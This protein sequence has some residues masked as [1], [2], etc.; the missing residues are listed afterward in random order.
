MPSNSKEIEE[1]LRNPKKAIELATN[2]SRKHVL[3]IPATIGAISSHF[4]HSAMEVILLC[5][6]GAERNLDLAE[7]LL[8]SIAS[9]APELR[10]PDDPLRRSADR[11]T[12]ART[13]ENT[14]VRYSDVICKA[15]SLCSAKSSCF[16]KE[17]VR[18]ASSL[19]STLLQAQI[20]TMGTCLQIL[21]SNKVISPEIFNNDN[22]IRV[23][24]RFWLAIV[25]ESRPG[26]VN[27]IV[28]EALYSC[29][30]VSHF[31]RYNSDFFDF[32]IEENGGDIHDTVAL[33]ISEL[34]ATTKESLKHSEDD[35]SFKRGH[36]A[37][38]H[39]NTM[40][41]FMP[42]SNA[43][44]RSTSLRL[45]I[46]PILTKAVF[47][48][49]PR[50]RLE[51]IH[52]ELNVLGY[53]MVMA[54]A[55][56]FP[57]GVRW[58]TEAIQAG[59]LSILTAAV[60]LF[61][62][63]R[64]FIT[65]KD[66]Q[67]IENIIRIL[68]NYLVHYPVVRAA[69]YGLSSIEPVMLKRME[70]FPFFPSWVKFRCA[71][72]ERAVFM[73]LLEKRIT[74]SERKLHCEYCLQM[75]P[76]QQLRKCERC[77]RTY[78]CSKTCQTK[79]WRQSDHKSVCA[80]LEGK[81]NVSAPLQTLDRLFLGHLAC[82]DIRRN[83]TALSLII[84]ENY[85]D[86]PLSK[87]RF[88][89][90][91]SAPGEAIGMHVAPMPEGEP[92]FL[93]RFAQRRDDDSGPCLVRVLFYGGTPE[94]ASSF[95]FMA[96]RTYFSPPKLLDQYKDAADT[97][98]VGFRSKIIYWCDP[99]ADEA[100]LIDISI[101]EAVDEVGAIMS[102]IRSNMG[103]S[104]DPLYFPS[105]FKYTWKDIEEAALACRRNWPFHGGYLLGS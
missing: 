54:D 32:L 78:Y 103:E 25:L 13:L 69:V 90:F 42:C 45:D 31:S 87:L 75:L 88:S 70:V 71:L 92:S 20:Q 80:N 100:S 2:G 76:L 68:S 83:M 98:N 17:G 46:V 56:I 16:T 67:N 41:A 28:H 73:S 30:N 43:T 36:T 62:R 94:Y 14:I 1:W 11:P 102:Y 38:I 63:Y 58:A 86:V 33:V 19:D 3:A 91:Y 50:Q 29:G 101:A 61:S 79:D 8:G 24:I 21:G 105:S 89:V 65:D 97:M 84:Q 4:H 47:E 48:E 85:S 99:G 74:S 77:R 27:P 81:N 51:L 93:S 53:L 49:M 57:G 23:P 59:M 34:R 10:K 104:E 96:P 60:A 82:Y 72:L 5:C 64:Q 18:T 66:L 35:F 55:L 12:S 26:D 37:L 95:H 6:F 52:S 9:L 7:A 39:L 22:M 15:L 44:L 40:M